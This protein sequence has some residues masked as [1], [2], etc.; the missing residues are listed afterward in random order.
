[1]T[2]SIHCHFFQ[3]INRYPIPVSVM[4]WR[5]GR[6]P[7]PVFVA[8]ASYNYANSC[9]VRSRLDPTSAGCG[10]NNELFANKQ[11]GRS[12]NRPFLF[13]FFNRVCFSVQSVVIPDHTVSNQGKSRWNR[14]AWLLPR[15][16][17]AHRNCTSHQ[18]RQQS[19]LLS[20][21]MVA[22]WRPSE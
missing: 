3:S 7:V 20:L 10:I 8:N 19:L 16:S 11:K 4:K 15:M 18:Q 14:T 2:L 12:F 17:T 1:M 21:L 22:H 6:D 9:C 5:G 13:R